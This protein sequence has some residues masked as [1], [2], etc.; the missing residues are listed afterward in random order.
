MSTDEFGGLLA[1]AGVVGTFLV[2]LYYLIG[3]IYRRSWQFVAKIGGSFA[4]YLL[5]I[6]VT[7]L[8]AVG[9]CAAGCPRGLSV[10]LGLFFLGLSL[11]IVIRLRNS[12]RRLIHE[13][14]PTRTS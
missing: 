10:L 6:V 3:A 5:G 12:H 4:L 8:F 9:L 2:H 13:S 1:A 11:V 14:T 7:F